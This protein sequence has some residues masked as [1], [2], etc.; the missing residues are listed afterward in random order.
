MRR[1]TLTTLRRP[2]SRVESRTPRTIR[3]QRGLDRRGMAVIGA[4][5]E[6][7]VAI[8]VARHNH[9]AHTPQ[10]NK[11][12]TCVHAAFTARYTPV[13]SESA[14]SQADHA[15]RGTRSH[16]SNFDTVAT[17]KASRH[18]SHSCNRKARLSLHCVTNRSLPFLFET[19]VTKTA[20]VLYDQSHCEALARYLFSGLR[21]VFEI[22][23]PSSIFVSAP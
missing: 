17:V 21:W 11:L 6:P 8:T 10:S 22:W 9:Q 20:W 13:R 19:V 4:T 7:Q 3:T 2:A 5:N 1:L 16:S 15:S 23:A 14:L 18:T 12:P